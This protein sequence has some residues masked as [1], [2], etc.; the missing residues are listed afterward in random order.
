MYVWSEDVASRGGQEIGSCLLKYFED[1]LPQ[2]VTQIILYSDSCGGQNRNIKVALLLKYFLAKQD[3]E[4][5]ILQKFFFSG[6]SYNSC[7]RQF[8][9]IEK[10]SKSYD[11]IETPD[12]WIRVIADSKN[13]DPRFVVT[14][15]EMADF[16][17]VDNLLELI[18]NRKVD[19][20]KNKVN[21]LKF[22][23]IVYDKEQ[24]MDIFGYDDEGTLQ[25]INIKKK[26]ISENAFDEAV[27]SL[28]YPFGRFITKA[29]YDDLQDLMESIEPRFRTFFHRLRSDGSANE[30]YGIASGASDAE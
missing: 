7:D 8:G 23:R 21:W 10:A 15:M 2:E 13:S 14:K 9:M 22:R 19:I 24:P 3:R 12:R 18:T 6:H 4:L 1:H 28:L 26:A 27:V 20:R 29:K 25:R 5:T 11:K 17:S 16:K 30:D